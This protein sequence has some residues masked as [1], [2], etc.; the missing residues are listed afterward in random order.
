VELHD[1][2]P[3]KSKDYFAETPMERKTKAVTVR[4]PVWLL[5]RLIRL[6]KAKTQ[7]ELINTLL[8][9]EEERLHSHKVLRRIAGTVKPSSIDDSLL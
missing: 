6:R 5:R 8:A 7:S 1:R 2:Q 9:D 4:I 3:L